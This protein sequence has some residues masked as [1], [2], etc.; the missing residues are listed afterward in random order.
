[1]STPLKPHLPHTHTTEKSAHNGEELASNQLYVTHSKADPQ[2]KQTE[3]QVYEAI[4]DSNSKKDVSASDV[5]LYDSLAPHPQQTENPLYSSM[6]GLEVEI[7]V[8][9]EDPPATPEKRKLPAD[10]GTSPH[11]GSPSEDHS[12]NEPMYSE[13]IPEAHPK[14]EP[15][16]SE[17]IPEP[18]EKQH[19]HQPQAT[20]HVYM[21][22]GPPVLAPPTENI[23]HGSDADWDDG[24]EGTA[25]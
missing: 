5:S 2:T 3:F 9:Q 12:T 1:M 8:K 23:K 16:Y 14:N 22:P 7:Q 20:D 25:L 24:S 15:M 19:S 18:S 11:T 10:Q 4:D 6:G 13:A 17:A 21:D